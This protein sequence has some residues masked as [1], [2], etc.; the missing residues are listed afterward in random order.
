MDF[1]PFDFIDDVHHQF[2]RFTYK[3]TNGIFSLWT[4]AQRMDLAE[5]SSN[6]SEPYEKRIVSARIHNT[7]DLS[8]VICFAFGS[9]SCKLIHNEQPVEFK[10]WNKRKDELVKIVLKTDDFGNTRE[11]DCEVLGEIK[12][13]LEENQYPVSLVQANCRKSNLSLNST[14]R[15]RIAH[16]TASILSVQ[17]LNV[18]GDDFVG[19]Y[20]FKKL[21]TKTTGGISSC[22]ENRQSS[23]LVESVKNGFVMHFEGYVDAYE[24]L[25][26]ALDSKDW[27][28]WICVDPRM[29]SSVEDRGLFA[30]GWKVSYCG[31]EEHDW[32]KVGWSAGRRDA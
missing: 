27:T 3:P 26:E 2:S 8:L 30:Q 11:I 23:S 6:W 10:S 9:I 17:F 12:K 19:N 14:Q 31:E 28:G 1:V 29:K 25:L 4:R 5:L 13:I 22:M 32:L 18:S 20:V 7:R 21:Q 15:S 16:I 24:E